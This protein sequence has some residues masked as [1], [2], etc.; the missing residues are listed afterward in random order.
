[1]LFRSRD[2]DRTALRILSRISSA[3]RHQHHHKEAMVGWEVSV[4]PCHRVL[5]RVLGPNMRHRRFRPSSQSN[6]RELSGACDQ[7]Q[8]WARWPAWV[9]HR[10]RAPAVLWVRKCKDLSNSSNLRRRRRILKGKILLRTWP[11]YSELS[12]YIVN[13]TC[14]IIAYL[15]CIFLSLF[16]MPKLC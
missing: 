4:Y 15:L 2:L 1:M 3:L 8:V 12:R 10:A 11:G 5:V 16:W 9:V 13:R 14:K 6:L 7:D